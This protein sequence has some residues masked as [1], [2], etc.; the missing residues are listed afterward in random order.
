VYQTAELELPKPSMD[1]IELIVKSLKNNNAPGQDNINSELI[2]IA[3]KDLLKTIHHLILYI[4]KS[5]IIEN[6]WNTAILCYIKYNEKIPQQYLVNIN[7]ASGKENQ[8][9]KL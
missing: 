9:V 2:K 8:P 3:G 6:D 5:E 4:W 7:L 1:K